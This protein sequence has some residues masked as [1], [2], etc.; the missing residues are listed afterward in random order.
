MPIYDSLFNLF[1][2]IQ[3]MTGMLIGPPPQHMIL[4]FQVQLIIFTI[5]RQSKQNHCGI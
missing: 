3:S 4:F 1:A 5:L 2:G